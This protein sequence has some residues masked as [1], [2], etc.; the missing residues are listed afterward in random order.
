[1]RARVLGKLFSIGTRKEAVLLSIVGGPLTA[2]EISSA[3]K[4]ESNKVYGALTDLIADRLVVALPQPHG[5]KMYC[6]NTDGIGALMDRTKGELE[7]NMK[8]L[9]AIREKIDRT[10]RQPFPRPTNEI[11]IGP[12]NDSL[13]QTRKLLEDS[14]KSILLSTYMFSWYKDIEDILVAKLRKK[15]H[16]TVLMINPKSKGIFSSSHSKLIQEKITILK[17]LGIDV[18]L[19][20]NRPSFRGTIV[21]ESICLIMTY[22]FLGETNSETKTGYYICKNSAIVQIIVSY[23]AACVREGTHALAG[24]TTPIGSSTTIRTSKL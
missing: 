17:D 22:P 19:L 13:E 6:L 15:I 8:T 21:D 24:N 5:P 23:F 4:L 16:A 11:W 10:P 18:Y 14:R 2:S 12:P 9:S 1:M 3:T 7:V 20:E